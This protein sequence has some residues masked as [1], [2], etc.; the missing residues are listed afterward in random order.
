MVGPSVVV[1]LAVGS[2]CSPGPTRPLLPHPSPW[3]PPS[4]P[5][6]TLA[7]VPCCLCSRATHLSLWG[8]LE[9]RCGPETTLWST[10]C[11][12]GP[13]SWTAWCWGTRAGPTAAKWLSLRRPCWVG[14]TWPCG[15]LGS[16]VFQWCPGSGWW[17]PLRAVGPR[18]WSRTG[19][20]THLWAPQQQG[21]QHL[22]RMVLGAASPCPA[23]WGPVLG[24]LRRQQLLVLLLQLLLLLPWR[25]G[26]GREHRRAGR[27]PSTQSLRSCRRFPLRPQV[28]QWDWGARR[29]WLHHLC[30]HQACLRQLQLRMEWVQAGGWPFGAGPPM[31]PRCCPLPPPTKRQ[32]APTQAEAPHGPAAPPHLQRVMRAVV[33]AL[34]QAPPQQRGA[35]SAAPPAGGPWA[36]PRP[37]PCGHH[38]QRQPVVSVQAAAG[39][40]VGHPGGSRTGPCL[41]SPCRHP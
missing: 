21:W 10:W 2:L 16:M 19:W 14:V 8:T 40:R 25:P 12:T 6:P 39:E 38:P 3:P 41:L 31:G 17:T 11:A 4:L 23:G 24:R 20:G 35:S 13:A 22:P 32:Q 30:R 33:V 28:L 7:A 5:G 36:S 15:K 27:P 26:R 9:P 29:P 37:H 18:T 1:W 34:R